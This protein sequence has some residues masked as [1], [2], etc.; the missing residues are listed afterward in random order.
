MH[1]LERIFGEF[2]LIAGGKRGGDKIKIL[3][4]K[5]GAFSD[6]LQSRTTTL[7]NF[8]SELTGWSFVKEKW[9]M[10]DL[11]AVNFKKEIIPVGKLNNKNYIA[12]LEKNPVSFA[13]TGTKQIEYTLKG[14]LF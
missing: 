9:V 14:K 12:T 3:E 8:L 5:N 2:R 11:E 1:D 4:I 10:D 13:I 6:D 7:I